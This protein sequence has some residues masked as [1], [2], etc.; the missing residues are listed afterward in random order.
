MKSSAW[1]G[2]TL[3]RLV[4]P[5][6]RR[7][8]TAQDAR[9]APAD[10]RAGPALSAG[11]R[12]P[13]CALADRHSEPSPPAP[14]LAELCERFLS[15]YERPRIKTCGL[16]CHGSYRAR[17]CCVCWAASGVAARSRG[18]RRWALH[19]ALAAKYK[20]ATVAMTLATGSRLYSW[21]L[22][23]GLVTENPFWDSICRRA[24]RSWNTL[25]RDEVSAL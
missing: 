11:S 17:T 21:A 15:E 9:D 10:P 12:G 14:T 19:R 7:R 13:G 22:G 20:P 24:S 6:H 5:L 25:S 4:H 1:C 18:A 16:P 23:R 3:P 2:R 8:S